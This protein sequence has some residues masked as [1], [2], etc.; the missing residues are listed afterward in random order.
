M[1]SQTSSDEQFAS[2]QRFEQ[3]LGNLLITGVAVAALVVLAG[4]ITFLI[5][6]SGQHA[7]Y[8]SFHGEPDTFC[9]VGGILKS[10][11]EWSGRGLI[12]LGLLLLIA[13]P[14][15]RVAFSLV[16]FIRQRDLVYCGFTL[17]VLAVLL[18]SLIGHG[19]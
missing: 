10:A 1:R 19:L 4:A 16:V 13:T 2:D 7:D 14:V 5:R 9:S 11:S 17:L 3:L 12:Q 8:A 6:H 18:F 15:A